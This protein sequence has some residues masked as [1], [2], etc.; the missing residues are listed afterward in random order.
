LRPV[1][2]FPLVIQAH[3]FGS[4]V[5]SLVFGH[6]AILLLLDSSVG[7]PELPPRQRKRCLRVGGTGA[8]L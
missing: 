6:D 1:A 5:L 8:R 2:A 7:I 3:Q 4:G